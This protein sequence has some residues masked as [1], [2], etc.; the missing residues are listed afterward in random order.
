MHDL[1]DFYGNIDEKP[2]LSFDLVQ[3]GKVF[4][5]SFKDILY[6]RYSPEVLFS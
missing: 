2:P 3:G 4:P 5:S 6:C 1:Q